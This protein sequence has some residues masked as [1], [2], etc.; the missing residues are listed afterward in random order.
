M[1]ARPRTILVA[2]L[3]LSLGLA[4]CGGQPEAEGQGSGM[5]DWPDLTDLGGATI[6]V[7]TDNQWVPWAYID[8]ADGQAKGFDH[9]LFAEICKRANCTPEFKE[10]SWDGLFEAGQ[11]GEWDVSCW[12]ITLTLERS[13]VIDYSDPIIQYG[14]IILTKADTTVKDLDSLVN[15]ELILGG[16]P[17]STEYIT[18]VKL[19]GEERVKAIDADLLIEGL[20]RDDYDAVVYDETGAY[21]VMTEYP[22]ELTI[23]ARVTSGEFVALPMRPGWPGQVAI[24]AALN[25]MW[26]DG[27]MQALVDKWFPGL[28]EQ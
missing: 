17:G 23:A 1:N 8:K 2:V 18:S 28:G 22:G 6:V 16:V 5:Q 20:L 25:E 13:K 7:A 12:G 4:A 26:K 11:A 14:A 15:S 3:L 9:D 10:F 24:N 21:G 27:S 19:V